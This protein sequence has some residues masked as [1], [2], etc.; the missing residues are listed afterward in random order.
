MKRQ[1][2]DCSTKILPDDIVMS[3]HTPTEDEAKIESGTAK[4][5][6]Y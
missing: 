3:D 4:C 2:W 1:V 5:E 6:F